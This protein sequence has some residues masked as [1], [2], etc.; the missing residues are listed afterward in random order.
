MQPSRRSFVVSSLSLTWPTAVPFP[1]PHCATTLR[2]T[3]FR[4]QQPVLATTTT[5]RGTSHTTSGCGSP[6]RTPRLIDSLYYRR[7]GLFEDRPL[8]SVPPHSPPTRA[9]SDSLAAK[10]AREEELRR[11]YS[12]GWTAEKETIDRQYRAARSAELDLQI[13]HL[14]TKNQLDRIR[15]NERADCDAAALSAAMSANAAS[16]PRRRDDLVRMYYSP[17]SPRFGYLSP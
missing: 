15:A 13:R 1:S 2:S 9:E 7:F 5:G 6:H 14:T 3:R 12:L 4:G 17:A 11:S 10:R 16:P 8:Y